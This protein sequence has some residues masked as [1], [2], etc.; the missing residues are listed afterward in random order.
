MNKK[1]KN[2]TTHTPTPWL[3]SEAPDERG[4]YHI[5]QP[6]TA[7]I[8]QVASVWGEGNAKFIVR[9]ANSHEE[10]LA[11]AKEAVDLL[12]AAKLKHTT[13]AQMLIAALAKATSNP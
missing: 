2:Q 8:G 7:H 12:E 3:M 11:A 9:A 10:F 5:N 1:T 13:G 6:E 4:Q